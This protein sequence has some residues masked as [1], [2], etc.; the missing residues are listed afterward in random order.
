M[1]TIYIVIASI[2]WGVV[3]S[4][5]AGNGFKHIV[6]KAFGAPAF[7]RLYRFAYNV[8]ALAS[9]F[10]ILLML[11]TFPDRLLYSIPSPW[12]YLMTV[13]QGLAALVMIAAV[14]QTGAFEFA[15]LAQL[16]FGYED[17]KPAGLVVDGLY[18]YVRH[19][20]YTAGLIFI[21][22]SPEMTLNR[23]V[24]WLIFSLYFVIG[25]IFEEKKLQKVFGS[26]YAEY[27][28]RTPML[29][30]DWHKNI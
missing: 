13:I 5:L 30:P 22:F 7:Y 24:L 20:I 6:R 16:S 23:L 28:A 26:E 12:L 19:P 3:H 15:G 29:I 27:K 25:A 1:G 8:F 10:P 11:V 2:L 18:A 9:F 4:V 14:M 21:W 17:S